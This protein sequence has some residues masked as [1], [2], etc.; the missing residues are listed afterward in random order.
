[1]KKILIFG[2]GSIGNHMSKA[3]I[4]SGYEIF[5]TDKSP[6]A[7]IRMKEKIY[8]MRYKNWNR[9][10]N[11]VNYKEVYKLNFFIDLIIIGTP[12]NTHYSIFNKC[13][14]FLDF[15]KILIEKPICHYSEKNINKLIDSSNTKMIFC[16]YNHSINPSM[17]FYYNLVKKNK[18]KVK[19][20]SILWKEGWDGIL[21]AHPWLKNE[22]DSYLGNYKHGGGSI[23]EHSHGL[24]ALVCISK[25]LGI[26]DLKIIKKIILFKEIKNKKYDYFSLLIFNI[27]KIL[28]KYETDLI[29]YPANKSI[30]INIEN[31]YLYW[32]CNY[33][34]NVDAV[35]SKINGNKKIFLF[36]KTRSSEFVNEIKHIMSL[37]TRDKYKKSPINLNNAIE[38]FKLIKNSFS[39]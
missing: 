10:I 4:D 7:L 26:K 27:K 24:H 36:K 38:V 33:K 8:P 25:I 37:R 6:E 34:K 21:G 20:I 18:L 39:L 28:I 11:I 2:A 19:N 15:N 17:S 35:I 14:K 23:H 9:K 5:I 13:S 29:S 3:G 31:G 32:F 16:G 1:M 22:F 12:P 30:S